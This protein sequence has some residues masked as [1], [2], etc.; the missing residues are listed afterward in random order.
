MKNEIKKSFHPNGQIAGEVT[1]VNGLPNGVTRRWHPNGVLASE[2]PVKDGIVEGVARQWNENGKL[3]GSYEIKNGT[4]TIKIWHPNGQLLGETPM[5]NGKWTGRQRAWFEDGTLAGNVYWIENQR[6]SKKKYDLACKANP[7]LPRYEGAVGAETKETRLLTS[8]A[9]TPTE[10]LKTAV[11][12]EDLIDPSRSK[13][14]LAWL[15]GGKPD[16]RS[17]GELPTTD[18]S[19]HMVKEL[20]SIGAT[21]VTAVNID[22]YDSGEENTGKLLVSLPEDSAARA[23]VLDWCAEWAEQLGFEPEC[24]VGQE[25]VFVMLD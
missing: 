20:Y 2:L 15:L 19:I 4:G 24:D 11:K 1:L 18:A 12:I 22:N 23:K 21:T 10:V 13:E 5:V 7:N 8:A 3:L 25:R 14:A 16:S 6:V 9:T 17:L